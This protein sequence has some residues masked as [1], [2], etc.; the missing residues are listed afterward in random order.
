[1]SASA[2]S[3]GIETALVWAA[4]EQKEAA[5]FSPK[6]APSIECQ[7][8]MNRPNAVASS[9]ATETPNIRLRQIFDFIFGPSSA[10]VLNIS[11]DR[12]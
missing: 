8:P 10:R 12:C 4:E 5:G 1:M 3:T 7:D 11:D 2:Q 9:P 6:R